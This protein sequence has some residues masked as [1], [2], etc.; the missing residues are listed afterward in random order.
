MEKIAAHN[1]TDTGQWR[2]T[3]DISETS[4]RAWLRRNDEPEAP[5]FILADATLDSDN[6]L[7]AIEDAV[8]DNSSMLDDFEADIILST[9]RFTLLPA[10]LADDAGLCRKAFSMVFGETAAEDIMTDTAAGYTVVYSPVAGLNSFLSRTFA[11]SRISCHISVLLNYWQPLAPGGPAM[12]ADIRRGYIDMALFQDGRLL[13]ASRHYWNDT[14]DAVYH[15][16]SAC[17]AAG[18]EIPQLAL[19]LSGPRD[20]TATVGDTVSDYIAGVQNIAIPHDAEVPA[21]DAI[22]SYRNNRRQS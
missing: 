2:L 10:E 6:S 20:L 13:S 19:F 18:T 11:G 9:P 22:C 5:M 14:D 16:L 17:R 3:A 1:I 15:L 21:A 7:S 8:Y 4:V 12:F